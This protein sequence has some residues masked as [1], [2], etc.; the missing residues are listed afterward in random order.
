MELNTIEV[1]SV[2]LSVMVVIIAVTAVALSFSEPSYMNA[3][4]VMWPR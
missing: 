1:I 4:V 3:N 2:A